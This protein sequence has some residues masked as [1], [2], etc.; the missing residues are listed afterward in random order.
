MANEE[1]R[2]NSS[3]FNALWKKGKIFGR[4]RK[5]ESE[6]VTFL[7]QHGYAR[8]ATQAKT[9]LERWVARSK[10]GFFAEGAKGDLKLTA[11][12]HRKGERVFRLDF[13]YI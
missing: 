12:D 8:S 1:P 4:K 9:L 5:T 11:L 7:L 13:H 10:Q 2:I 6:A 3:V